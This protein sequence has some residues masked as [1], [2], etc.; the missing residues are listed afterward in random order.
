M[1]EMISLRTFRLPSLTGHVILFEANTPRNVPDAVVPEAMAAGCVPT[2]AAAIPFHE[3]LSRA[4]VE[5]QGDVRRSMLFLAVKL[6]A[7]NN[8]AKDFDGG[9]TPKTTVVAARLGY[10]V[11]RQ[12][13]IDVYQ[14]Y[15]TVK[16]EGREYALHPQ[17]Q[18]ILRVLEAESKDELIDLAEEFGV[19]GAKAKGLVVKDLR[20]LLLVKFSGIAAG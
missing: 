2:D 4:K 17:A 3:D 20:K 11:S 5:F 14:Q 13:V 6:I 9:G 7:E 12:E 1:P 18:N 8:V 10:E 19:D 16:S 15:L